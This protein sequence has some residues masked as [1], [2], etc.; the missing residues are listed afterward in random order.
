MT[1]DDCSG[2]VPKGGQALGKSSE[3]GVA[4]LRGGVLDDGRRRW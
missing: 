1:D 4:D 2:Q 3:R